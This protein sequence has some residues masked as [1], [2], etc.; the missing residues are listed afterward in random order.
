MSW[1]AAE[2]WQGHQHLQRWPRTLPAYQ[3]RRLTWT[4]TPSGA[5]RFFNRAG[6]GTI[7][8]LKAEIR[9]GKCMKPN[10]PK[11]LL[12]WNKPALWPVSSFILTLLVWSALGFG[13]RGWGDD[14][15]SPS[16]FY[17]P[18]AVA[19][20]SVGNVFVADSHNHTIRELRPLGTN[21][22]SSTIAGV[23]GVVGSTDGAHNA[24]LFY[25]PFGIAVDGRGDLYVADTE[26][27][28]IR[29]LTSTG[30]NWISTTIAGMAGSADFWCPQGIAVDRAGSVY[31]A[32]PCDVTIRKLTPPGTNW[33]TIASGFI[34]D[35][36]IGTNSEGPFRIP[37]TLRWTLRA[38]CMSPTG[39]TRPSTN[40]HRQ[41]PI[42]SPAPSRGESL[43]YAD[44]TNGAA[45]FGKPTGIA[46]DSSGN[47]YVADA[48]TSGAAPGNTTIRKLTPVGT[49]WVSS[50]IAGSTTGYSDGTNGLARFSEPKGLA[51][52]HA[53]NLY[54]ADSG[55][56]AIR[57]LTPVGSNW[58]STTISGVAGLP[59]SVDGITSA[60]Q[61]I[62][63]PYSFG[64]FAGGGQSGSFHLEGSICGWIS[65]FGGSI[66]P[67]Q[68]DY[69]SPFEGWAPAPPITLDPPDHHGSF[70]TML[71]EL[72]WGS[73]GVV[74]DNAG[75]AYIA[76]QVSHTIRKV[77]AG[78]EFARGGL[79]VCRSWPDF[80]ERPALRTGSV[81]R[82][83]STIRPV[84]R[85]TM[86]ATF[87]LP[88]P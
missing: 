16:Q 13:Q 42:G 78:G 24:A 67:G 6:S 34:A 52:D 32:D 51:L 58:V 37:K 84:W 20:D 3:A 56:H 61:L 80:L 88:I 9:N 75:N 28:T 85:Q 49:N 11:N 31:V 41:G 26:N 86:R 54:A 66:E 21:W 15:A 5:G 27:H 73:S 46:L 76:D 1:S 10:Q 69:F 14:A 70:C 53:G 35:S 23:P 72:F 38:K 44:G 87:S 48:Q 25:S 43:G 50:T 57:Q 7:R 30:T 33:L 77:Q 36:F 68:E 45:R 62:D 39:A 74:L 83:V 40:S 82:R 81:A 59:G 12:P 17:N 63:E 4:P 79:G 29:K 22:V 18:E 71:P 2:T 8:N 19:V 55:N 60:A 47:L 65:V 64:P